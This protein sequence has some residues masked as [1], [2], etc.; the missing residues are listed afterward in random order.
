[1]IEHGAT[2]TISPDDVHGLLRVRP[3]PPRMVI[4][5]VVTAAVLGV[6]WLVGHLGHSLGFARAVGLPGLQDDG[7][8]LVLGLRVLGVV[9]ACIGEAA[10]SATLGLLVVFAAVALPA[11]I[12]AALL[13][14]A[15]AARSRGGLH[16]IAG[17]VGCL[18]S[19]STS[20]WL[21]AT[22][23]AMTAM[24]LAEDPAT[25]TGWLDRTRIEGA[26]STCL[27]VAGVLWCVVILR[28][29]AP[30][31]F[32]SLAATLCAASIVTCMLVASASLGAVE[33]LVTARPVLHTE[34]GTRMMRLG[35]VGSTA[36]LVT[37]P[38][39]R[40]GSSITLQEMPGTTTLA[41]GTSLAAWLEDRTSP[42]VPGP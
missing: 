2:P 21:L 39:S 13:G 42:S 20:G 14:E 3:A 12:L 6:L 18:F 27:L 32:R 26:L 40:G 30:G 17:T 28:L 9:P 22:F 11:A 35:R 8:S 37:A 24:P 31:W 38:S 1:M 10:A 25:L 36:V 29:H 41:G 19:V 16:V 34:D 4:A 23:S 33:G 7:G 15:P 5:M